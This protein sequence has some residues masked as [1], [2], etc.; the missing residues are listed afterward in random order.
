M[1]HYQAY[2]SAANYPNNLKPRQIHVDMDNEA[3]LLPINGVPVPFHI[4]T[5]KNVGKIDD[6]ENSY[7]RIN[8]HFPSG[9]TQ[10]R[11]LTGRTR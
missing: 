2:K 5:V 6:E 3:I 11:R 7:L 1:D 9:A 10:N 8:F 4:S